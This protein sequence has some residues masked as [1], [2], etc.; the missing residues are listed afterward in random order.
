MTDLQYLPAADDVTEFTATVTDATDDYLVL[1]GTYFYPEGGGQ[2]A[3]HGRLEW[4]GGA[5]TVTNVRKDHGDV[6]HEVETI[7]GA[8]PEPGTDVTG[9]ID[10]ER[11]DRLRRMH[12][13]QHVVSRVVLDEYGASTAGNQIHPDRSRI[14]FEPADFDEDDV[15]MIQER[16]N[17]AIERDL[18]V[19]KENR[20][21]A[22]VEREVDEGRSLLELIPDH[23]DPLRV[24]AIEDWDMCPC[25][26]THVDR[27]G[28]I[29]RIELTDRTPKGADV[30][31]IEFELH[32]P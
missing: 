9:E 2:P 10:A 6:R 17:A 8:V 23:V 16:S 5:A 12:T 3:D 4:D 1:D 22:D 14:D 20:A 31:R 28:E 11:R 32:E 19:T 15:E 27:L 24:V 21:R 7:E 26:G 29:G 18:S 30:E 13:A 25:G